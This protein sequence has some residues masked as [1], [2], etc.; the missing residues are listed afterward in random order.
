MSPTPTPTPA[1]MSITTTLVQS[2]LKTAE[3]LVVS[4]TEVVAGRY[5][6]RV[7]L[8]KQTTI[9]ISEV[10]NSGETAPLKITANA[11]K[12]EIPLDQNP[13]MMIN[14]ETYTATLTLYSSSSNDSDET[15]IH[16]TVGVIFYD[17]RTIT[18][19]PIEIVNNPNPTYLSG[20]TPNLTHSTPILKAD[21]ADIN[22]ADSLYKYVKID[23][24]KLT[25]TALLQ[26]DGSFIAADDYY[27]G[28]KSYAPT[29]TYIW[30][31]I[32]PSDRAYE[33]WGSLT[34]ETA[35]T[36]TIAP[37]QI[38]PSFSF[39]YEFSST[40]RIGYRLDAP[41]VTLELGD[42]LGVVSTNPIK[43]LI[44]NWDS[45]S[46]YKPDSVLL[47]IRATA[48]MSPTLLFS[49][50]KPYADIVNKTCIF[51]VADLASAANGN[52]LTN[53]TTYYFETV[54][55]FTNSALYNPTQYRSVVVADMF[56]DSVDAVTVAR[57]TNSWIRDVTKPDGLVVAFKK[58]T[59]FMGSTDVPYNLDKYGE[60][61]V[62]A[63]YNV[64]DASGNLT[65]WVPLSG[66]SISQG[67]VDY[68]QN[69]SNTDGRYVVPKHDSTSSDGSS[70]DDVN[71]YAVIPNQNQHRLVQVRLSLQSNNS[72]FD[73][74]KRTSLDFVVP[75]ESG[76][77]Y[78]FAA[79]SVR[80]FPQP[81]DHSFILDKSFIDTLDA[82]GNALIKVAVR[83][84]P[85]FSSSITTSGGTVSGTAESINYNSADYTNLT[86]YVP[87]TGNITGAAAGLSYLPTADASFQLKV[88]YVYSE[89]TSISTNEISMDV[90]MQGFPSNEFT[91]VSA[92]W[93]KDTQQLDY[94]LNVTATSTSAYRVD[95][96]VIYNQVSTGGDYA[97]IGAFLRSDGSIRK[98]DLA[99]SVPDFSDIDIKF[100]ATRSR[101]LNSIATL[102]PIV[103]DQTELVDGGL[104]DM[105]VT[106]ITT[107]PGGLRK[108]VLADIELSN[109][110]YD[111]HGPASQSAILI[112]KFPSNA[113]IAGVRV[114]NG[115]DSLF[116]SAN[117][118]NTQFLIALG[119]AS[120]TKSYKIAYRYDT[121][122]L[123]TVTSV[124]SAEVTLTFK[125]STS[126]ASV[127]VIV[128][129]S[130]VDES[131]FTVSYTSSD[132]SG[133]SDAAVLT[134]KVMVEQTVPTT[135]VAYIA[136]RA[137][138]DSLNLSG[139]KGKSITMFIR[140]SFITTYA[141]G[142]ESGTVTQDVNRTGVSF[143]VAA[144]PAIVESSF[145]VKSGAKTITFDVKNNGA[146]FINNVLLMASQDASINENDQGTFAVA[147]FAASGG[148]A[149]NV[150]VTN[151][152][153]GGTAHTLTVT[154]ITGTLYDQVTSF[155]FQSASDISSVAANIV[156][157]VSN[158]VEGADSF[159]VSVT[160]I[161]PPLI[162][163]AA[164]GITIQ[165][166]GTAGAIP[167]SEPLFLQANPRGTGLE[168]F[169]VINNSSKSMLMNYASNL[170]SGLG[171]DYFTKDGY[172]VDF[173]NIVTTLMTD[174]SSLFENVASFN[175]DISSWDTSSVTTMSR[176]FRNTR[177]FNVN[178]GGWNVSN[179]LD[180]SRMFETDPADPWSMFNNGGSGDIGNWNTSK[181]TNMS[182][183]FT[184]AK[185]FNQN[186]SG[187]I[188][189]Q[190]TD[191]SSIF[192][193]AQTF[194]AFIQTKAPLK[195]R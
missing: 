54:L 177:A 7:R 77:T 147:M 100:V 164:N 45:Y 75:T 137:N 183:M 142:A 14:G 117:S 26:E 38:K 63:E 79:A 21:G 60:T 188:V 195:F 178:I 193:N 108:P 157:Y 146:P 80:F 91:I 149:L 181:V 173:K 111:A 185:S 5:D 4:D 189:S 8:V 70:Q 131:T 125:T 86:S 72:V 89:N 106:K 155:K 57:A 51:T 9:G 135:D 113:N 58:S 93:N 87:V 120:E 128:S 170:S 88:K 101:W 40:D 166:T 150:P 122:V 163:R 84:P 85:F 140:N 37:N 129:K 49:M 13:T 53:G 165:Y 22:S 119:S 145:E 61:T 55:E 115:D 99:G 175:Q 134:Q 20:T 6:I 169:A 1:P 143:Y 52:P 27:L 36:F 10:G 94:V 50:S 76:Y 64:L 43:I 34:L 78:P 11:T 23:K 83:V 182:R 48:D 68:V 167:S 16:R 81:A 132:A 82:S 24:I 74:T 15:I 187:W 152:L 168:W 41:S 136:P 110:V 28:A 96:W 186:V 154:A 62:L 97:K 18:V 148:F 46:T 90:Q 158:A 194:A 141:F 127:P 124:Y 159:A 12:L 144:N 156:A 3:F 42:V 160:P 162:E 47:R 32:L 69:S 139:Y 126:S 174:M 151:S 29:T 179:V 17:A 133:V 2:S 59:Q 33:C 19:D 153:S 39:A 35:N 130:Y 104:M 176:M 105:K 31:N 56:K 161:I 25:A 118:T 71:I 184:S 102:A 138:A 30:D 44:S 66:G 67:S 191:W 98:T 192:A 114:N 180:M 103:A 92:V 65:A 112:T 73:V 190:V 116:G 107:V 95:G 171:R 121:Y 172:T 123:G 109:I